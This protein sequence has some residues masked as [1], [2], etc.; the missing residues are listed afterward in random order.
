MKNALSIAGLIEHLGD[1]GRSCPVSE[2]PSGFE[3]L[4]HPGIYAWWANDY[5]ANFMSDRLGE[6]IAPGIVYI[7][8]AGAIKSGS[9]SN[10]N[11]FQRLSSN[12]MG[13][14]LRTS[15]FRLSIAAILW[16]EVRQFHIGDREIGDRGEQQ[17]SQW[18]E[19]NFRL[20]AAPFAD[21][22]QLRMAEAEVLSH[23]N[24]AL[25]LA[26]MGPSRIRSAL[27]ARRAALRRSV[28]KATAPHT[29]S[30]ST[31]S[32][33]QAI[34]LERS[35]SRQSAITLH[36][37]IAQIL[38]EN[39]NQ[40]LSTR[41]IAERVNSRGRY[42]KRDGSLITD[43]QVHGRTRNYSHIFKRDGSRVALVDL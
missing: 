9:K 16:E 3:D 36:E 18:I 32:S 28:E 1:V 27:T 39:G 31:I 10:S 26:G 33:S 42:R 38:I 29:Q 2:F 21:R 35:H 7:G 20:V 15:T 8:Q 43:F 13:G 37:E 23:F 12:H 25:N 17:I 22:N 11:L 40:W 41:Q 24:P 5:A 4:D 19:Q 30:K 6:E 14:T 34:S